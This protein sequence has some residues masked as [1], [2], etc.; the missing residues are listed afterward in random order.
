MSNYNSWR[1]E[2]R[3][4]DFCPIC[5]NRLPQREMILLKKADI[6]RERKLTRL[7]ENCFLKVL[8]FIGISDVDLY[9]KERIEAILSK[10]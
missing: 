6:Y 3:Y 10:Y 7:C 2:E 1:S 8:D 4:F 5:G 9:E